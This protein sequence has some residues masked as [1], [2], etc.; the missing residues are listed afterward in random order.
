M[1]VLRTYFVLLLK[2]DAY[3]DRHVLGCSLLFAR[4]IALL[5]CAVLCRPRGSTTTYILAHTTAALLLVAVYRYYS[6]SARYAS[7]QRSIDRDDRQM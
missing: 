6:G 4:V 3:S 2:F 5:C 1:H 7:S